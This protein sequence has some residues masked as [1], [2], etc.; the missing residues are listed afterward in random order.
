[1]LTPFCKSLKAISALTTARREAEEVL[2]RDDRITCINRDKFGC[3][4]QFNTSSRRS[5]CA[6]RTV[7]RVR[8]KTRKNQPSYFNSAAAG[9]LAQLVTLE[10]DF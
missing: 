7:G 5:V 1:M 4:Y 10:P 8:T 9:T 3:T 6:L 2:D